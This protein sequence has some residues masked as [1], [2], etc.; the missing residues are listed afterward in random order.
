MGIFPDNVKRRLKEL[1][2]STGLRD[3]VG[4]LTGSLMSLPTVA[5]LRDTNISVEKA[6]GLYYNTDPTVCNGAF[7]AK[8]IIDGVADHVGIPVCTTNDPNTDK[9][10]QSWL[11]DTWKPQM[12]ELYRNALRDTKVFVRIRKPFSTELTAENEDNLVQLEIIDADRAVTFYNP[13]TGEL[14]KI[15]ILNE[16]FV[17]DETNDPTRP[18]ILRG[19]NHQIYE[20][21]TKGRY[22]YYDSTEGRELEELAMDNRWGFV[23]VVEIFNDYD[24]AL[25]GGMSELETVFPFF[26]ALHDLVLQTRSIHKYHA[27]PKVKFKIADVMSFLRNNFKE[28]F[29]G[30]E[31]T[32]T[33]NWQGKDVFFMESEEDAGFIEA[34]MQTGDSVSLMEFVIDLMCVAGE[35]PEAMLFRAKAEYNTQTDE[36]FRFK[37]KITRKRSN[38]SESIIEL[39]KMAQKVTLTKVLLPKM[40]WPIID[41][42][43]QVQEATALNQVV[44][45]SEVAN[46]AGVISKKTYSDKLREYFPTMADYDTEQKQI[47]KEQSAEQQQQIDFEKKMEEVK[48]GSQNQNGGGPNSASARRARVQLPMDVVPGPGS[49]GN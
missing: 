21:I 31:F 45:G 13:I 26:Q 14:D 4:A 38:F 18:G 10:I 33:V 32:G 37:S 22:T 5:T 3:S 11:Q 12:W 29:N 15:Q 28:S 23:P 7:F 9:I 49:A 25:N 47:D 2:A 17:E 46:R 42:N 39:I 6:R 27:N 43:D 16:V 20:T 41:S 44:T 30:E 48:A 8:T 36:M 35:I 1:R 40:T 24:S 34:T 19:K